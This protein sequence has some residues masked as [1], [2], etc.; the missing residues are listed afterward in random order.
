M[1]K[2]ILDVLVICPILRLWMSFLRQAGV[3]LK[4]QRFVGQ[5]H[6]FFV[7]ANILPGSAVGRAFVVD[8]IAERIAR[9]GAR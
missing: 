8:A 7:M 6:G 2:K 5:V 9:T 4:H 1:I 3:E